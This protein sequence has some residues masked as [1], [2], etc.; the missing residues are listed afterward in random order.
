LVS[1]EDTARVDG[2][3]ACRGEGREKEA[4]AK[5]R[6]EA[7]KGQLPRRKRGPG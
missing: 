6:A 4:R 2:D 3:G 1:M 7:N 5:K